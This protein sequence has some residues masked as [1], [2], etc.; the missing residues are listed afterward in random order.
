PHLKFSQLIKSSISSRGLTYISRPPTDNSLG[1]IAF[2]TTANWA[3]NLFVLIS[4]RYMYIALFCLGFTLSKRELV[5][6]QRNTKNSSKVREK[7]LKCTG[8][9]FVGTAYENIFDFKKHI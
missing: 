3:A 6:R 9:K 4:L 8:I 5:I 7:A 2:I 1:R